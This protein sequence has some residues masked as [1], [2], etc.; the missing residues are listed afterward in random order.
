MGNQGVYRYIVVNIMERNYSLIP[1]YEPPD[2]VAIKKWA[3]QQISI[4]HRLCTYLWENWYR[5]GR[6]ALWARCDEHKFIPVLKT[7]MILES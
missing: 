2:A 5:K 6:W 7:I 3:V 4:K 1:G